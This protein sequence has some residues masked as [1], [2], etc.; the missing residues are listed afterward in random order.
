M[1]KPL[2]PTPLSPADAL[3]MKRAF[4]G[5]VDCD[6]STDG[7][8]EARLAD[9]RLVIREG[10]RD[11]FIAAPSGRGE[12]PSRPSISGDGRRVAWASEGDGAT[13]RVTL[14]GARSGLLGTI[15]RL[16]WG[17]TPLDVDAGAAFDL[18]PDGRQVAF[19]RGDAIVVA[20]TTSHEE[21]ASVLLPAVD[22][23]AQRAFDVEFLPSGHVAVETEWSTFRLIDVGSGACTPVPLRDFDPERW[24]S[25]L[26]AAARAF[27][28]LSP[29][30]LTFLLDRYGDT[31][32]GALP[33]PDR[34][35]VLVQ[36]ARTEGEVENL[37]IHRATQQR[38]SLGPSDAPDLA[39]PET[40]PRW[41]DDG[42]S[43]VLDGHHTV[44]VPQVPDPW[45]IGAARQPSA[46]SGDRAPTVLVDDAFVSIGGVRVPRRPPGNRTPSTAP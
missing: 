9:H 4:S 14:T 11:T 20:A 18:S 29:S 45:I 43:I 24:A 21:S 35:Y 2:T 22:L 40:A 5:G 30:E 25:R 19:T 13:G 33:S 42:H 39:R 16:C 7:A 31:V 28:E 44:Q 6:V 27:P 46:P 1:M 15:E 37:L 23:C 34:R 3:A 41:S 8:R 17:R 38:Y 12:R 32:A 10:G 26:G 36:L